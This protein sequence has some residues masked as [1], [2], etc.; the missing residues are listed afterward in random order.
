MRPRSAYHGLG[1]DS[2]ADDGAAFRMQ[3]GFAGGDLTM[4]PR[5]WLVFTAARRTR[6]T[7]SKDPTGDSLPV[8]GT[9]TPDTRRCRRDPALRA[10]HRRRRL[11]LAAGRRLRAAR[12]ALPGHAPS[13]RRSRRHLQL[14][15]AR[16]RGRAARSDPARE[17]GD[18][19][20]RP[21][22]SPRSA[23]TIRCRTS[24]CRRSAAA[25]RCA[26][27]AAGAFAIGTPCWS[28][29]SGAGLRTG[30][31]S[32]WRCSTTP[33]WWRRASMRIAAAIV[34][35]RLRH[36]RPFP[37]ARRGRRCASSSR[38]AAKARGSSFRASAA[39]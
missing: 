7:R 18:L 33:A 12:R 34:R 19:V 16:C 10:H 2:P 26:A 39:F 20:A 30:W 9:F 21:A 38:T 36:R 22:A 14:R 37:R 13:L 35:Q 15:S 4:R 24:C 6:T 8:E 11:R 32:T 3:Q 31:R 17:L 23:T 27:T 1:I 28:S 25:A 5:R 29:A